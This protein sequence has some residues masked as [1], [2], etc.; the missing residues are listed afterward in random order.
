[1][2]LLGLGTAIAYRVPRAEGAAGREPGEA[3]GWPGGSGGA[4]AWVEDTEWAACMD[5]GWDGPALR[6]A[7]TAVVRRFEGVRVG[8]DAPAEGGS[9]AAGGSEGGP[10]RRRAVLLG[11]PRQQG[12][13]KVCL[14]VHA[15]ALRPV[16]AALAEELRGGAAAAGPRPSAPPGAATPPSTACSGGP[17]STPALAAGSADGAAPQLPAGVRL[18]LQR[19]GRRGEWASVDVVPAG[20]GKAAALAHVAARFRLPAW[21]LVAAGDTDRDAQLLAA[22]GAAVVTAPRPPP[23]L[24]ALLRAGAA[25]GRGGWSCVGSR[26][27]GPAGLLEGLAQL[28]LV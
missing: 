26:V 23:G 12:R 28:G 5:A 14:Q 2:L 15:S 27:A 18:V 22:A 11:A 7:A 17:H 20:A 13:H 1:V 19:R 9:S 6:S 3:H 21:A 16:L 8:G 4:W 24:A 25:P 10:A